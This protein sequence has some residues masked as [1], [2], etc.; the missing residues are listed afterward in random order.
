M[1]LNWI[2]REP[3]SQL[4][5]GRKALGVVVGIVGAAVGAAIR[6]VFGRFPR[7]RGDRP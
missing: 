4:D 2:H 6:A 7:I 5:T 3:P 1:M